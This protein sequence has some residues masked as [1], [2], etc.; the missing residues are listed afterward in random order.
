MIPLKRPAIL[1][2]SDAAFNDFGGKSA[3]GLECQVSSNSADCS[4]YRLLYS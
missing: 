1:A 2:L 3:K 4:W